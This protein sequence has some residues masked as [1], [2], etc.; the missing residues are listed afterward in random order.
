MRKNVNY[1]KVLDRLYECRNLEISNL[2]QRSIFLSV[3]ITLCFAGYG[4]LIFNIIQK[5]DVSYYLE[6]S[7][8]HLASASLSFVGC[9]L[10]A[11]WI[12]MSKGSKA[13]YEVYEI[14]ISNFEDSYRNE[15]GIPERYI[16]GN[17]GVY[18]KNLNNCIL[19][20]KA[21]A[22]SPSRINVLIGQVCLAG[23]VVTFIVHSLFFGFCA[24]KINNNALSDPCIFKYG[25]L[26]ALF[27]LFACLCILL[28]KTVPPKYARSKHLYDT[29][30]DKTGFQHC[31]RKD[32]EKR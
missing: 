31:K 10:S 30:Y 6:L 9:I 21:G 29:I 28:I 7:Y 11:I 26:I 32:W 15:L 8:L 13:W 18:W 25:T 14:A 22:Y 24:F 20:T 3:F 4:I 12:Y 19:S 1:V 17:M 5:C 16:M 27:L 23:W 2:W